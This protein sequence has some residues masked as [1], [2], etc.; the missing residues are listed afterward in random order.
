MAEQQT[1]T[2]TAVLEE[3]VGNLIDDVRQI[4]ESTAQIAESMVR[5]ARI[6]ERHVATTSSLERAFGWTEQLDKRVTVIETKPGKWVDR[7]I[8]AAITAI[9]ATLVAMAVGKGIVA[10]SERAMAAA[11]QIKATE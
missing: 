9:V 10:G 3:R 6:E 4:K 8:H 1:D 7:A 11:P 5:L 2:R